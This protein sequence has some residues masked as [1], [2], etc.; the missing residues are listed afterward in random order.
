MYPDNGGEIHKGGNNWP[1][2]GYKDT[3]WE[4]GMHGIGFVHSSL[5]KTKGSV[6]HGLVHVSDWFPT[7]IKLAGGNVTGMKLDGHDVWPTVRYNASCSYHRDLS[8]I[9]KLLRHR[10]F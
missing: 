4:G 10:K 9:T 7:L 3:L 5:L 2:R 8:I 1:L 6:S